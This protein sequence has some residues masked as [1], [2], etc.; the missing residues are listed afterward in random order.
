MFFFLKKLYISALKK[1]EI[2]SAIAVRLTKYTGKSKVF[3]HPKHFL[4]ERPWFI[5]FLAKNDIVLDLGSSSGQNAIKS[6]NYVKK[7]VGI[8]IDKTLLDIS[9]RTIEEKKIKNVKFIEGNLEKKLSFKNKSFDKVIFLD[10]LEHL[11]KRDQILSEIHRILK[12]KGLLIIGVPNK[13][14]SW[15][16]AQRSVSMFSYSDP[17]HKI[18]FSEAEIKKLL[19]KHSFHIIQFNY[20]PYDTPFRGFYDIIGVFSLSL[21]KKIHEWRAIKSQKNGKEASGFEIVAAK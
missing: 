10:V 16:K 4:N 13:E 1:I 9:R 7:I 21:Y 3:I 2:C 14:T 8:E 11:I 20:A 12:S 15:K 5:K 6:S 17:D 18:E 19:T